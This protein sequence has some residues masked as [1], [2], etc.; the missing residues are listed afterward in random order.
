MNTFIISSYL[1]PDH[2]KQEAADLAVLIVTGTTAD[3]VLKQLRD[4][5]V[6]KYAAD[7]AVKVEK[8]NS[9]TTTLATPGSGKL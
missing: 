7:E 5:V 8:L 9:Y 2:K 4:S 1:N 6:F 3:S